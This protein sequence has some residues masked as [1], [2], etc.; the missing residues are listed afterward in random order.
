LRCWG[1]GLGKIGNGSSAHTSAPTI[2]TGFG[3]TSPPP[4]PPVALIPAPK[5][6]AGQYHTCAMNASGSVYCWG[7]NANGQ[8]GIGSSDA[9]R[10]TPVAVA[11]S[12]ARLSA[13][14]LHNCMVTTAGGV[15]CWGDNS[16]GQLGTGAAGNASSPVDASGLGT[17]INS[18]AAGG[19]HTCVL[20]SGNAVRC[21]GR[22]AEGQLGNGTT[23][24]SNVAVNV[25]GISGVTA[26]GTGF[27]HSCAI[28]GGGAL[29][30]W[31]DNRYGQLGDGTTTNRSAPVAVTSVGG[32]VQSVHVGGYHT[33]AVLGTNEVRCW[34][35]NTYGQ[36]GD[37]TTVNRATPV[38]SASVLVGTALSSGGYHSCARTTAGAAICWGNNSSG[39]VGDGT[40]VVRPLPALVERLAS[41]VGAVATGIYHSCALMS[42]GGVRCW[43]ENQ[44]GQRG[45]G[46]FAFHATP[47]PVRGP[48]GSGF[49]DLTPSDGITVPPTYT[50]SVAVVTTGSIGASQATVSAVITPQAADAG[51]TQSIFVY[52][53]APASVV[54]AAAAK[55]GEEELPIFAKVAGTA[56]DVPVSCVL[57]QLNASGQLQQANASALQAYVTSVISSQGATVKVL[58]GISTLSIGGA[59]FFVG[60]GANSQAMFANGTSATVATVPGNIECK[61]QPPQTGW[62]WNPAEGGRGFSIEYNGKKLFMAAY[63]YEDDGRASWLVASGPTSLDGSTFTGDLLRCAGGQTLTGAYPGFPNCTSPGKVAL[64]FNSA[65]R[66]TMVWPGGSVPIERFGMVPGGLT[67]APQAG[68]PETGWWWNSA[69]SGRGFF[70]EWQNGYADLAGYMYDA[71]GRP[72]WYISVYPTPDA[73]RFTGN[74]WQYGNGQTMTGT[75]RPAARVNDNVGSI[76]LE[77][78]DATRATLTLPDGRRIPLTRFSF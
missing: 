73:R 47:E 13:G 61:P 67:A 7:G 25:T 39:Q 12:A 41:G 71:S 51:T 28:A 68:Q 69:E 74:W 3:A 17:G 43:G 53:L 42:D 27:T 30:C 16:A 5:V 50:A 72:L 21:F 9:S 40:Q 6:A 18:V 58:D 75:Y 64:T 38:A 31:G 35:Q 29:Y 76:V 36:L 52:A 56:K 19:L 1:Y 59:T 48:G 20:T 34:G 4:P 70:I 23:T 10:S 44:Q 65:T 32:G 63:L 15:R 57:A 26:I 66:G 54:R 24:N 14:A 33:C 37:G 11:G 45:N 2:V 55:S 62:W 22:N 78:S 46:N 60:Y 49:L 8:L 77:F